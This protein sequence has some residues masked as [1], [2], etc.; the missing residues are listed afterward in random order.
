MNLENAF[1]KVIR[2]GALTAVLFCCRTVQAE[3]LSVSTTLPSAL[4]QVSESAVALPALSAVALPA[5]SAVAPLSV[6]QLP[7]LGVNASPYLASPE[8]SSRRPPSGL[9]KIITG[10]V[11]VGLGALNLATLPICFSD[12]YKQQN[13]KDICI[14][15]S[16]TIA[17]VG[18]TVG[19]PLLLVGYHQR[20]KYKAW[21]EQGALLLER[22][23]VAALPGGG[24]VLYTARF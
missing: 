13:T 6:V 5:L 1:E 18:V 9:G 22:T 8:F 2:L 24:E 14:G 21:E 20:K 23:T 15:A 4:G 3:P 16:A 10:W 11:F 12:V 7:A 19:L 17:V